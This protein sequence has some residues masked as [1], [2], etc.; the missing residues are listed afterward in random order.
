MPFPHATAPTSTDLR[1][2]DILWPRH[3][4]V[5]VIPGISLES[6]LTQ[7]LARQMGW[8]S[9]AAL[10]VGRE[11]ELSR[12]VLEK[13]MK[14]LGLP[15]D[16]PGNAAIAA[17]ALGLLAV[18]RNEM[19]PEALEPNLG[20]WINDLNG[21]LDAARDVWTEPLLD[22]SYL[23][24][25][26]GGL[27]PSDL[28]AALPAGWPGG[29]GAGATT[30]LTRATVAGAYVGHL[31][32]VDILDGQPWVIES[33]YVAGGVQITPYA[34]W[35]HHRQSMEAHVWQGR[36]VRSGEG[37]EP[38]NA[39]QL[40]TMLDTAHSLRMQRKRYAIFDRT[41]AGATTPLG[42]QD[43]VYCSELVYLSARSVGVDLDSRQGLA[44]KLPFLG[45]KAISQSP[46]VRMVFRP[47][48]QAY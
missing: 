18:L 8:P 6:D 33:S 28:Q 16:I 34:T 9:P 19:V 7:W 35:L 40:T 48:S 29:A 3:P 47:G 30:V 17:G 43:M 13:W 21:V 31:G 23:S 24:L 46:H 36:V 45:P 12:D 41:A 15:I 32:M 39:G 20:D 44:R 37:Q 25:A 10:A 11:D 4:D 26:L 14:I 1:K 22:L 38:L 27:W 42:D 2:G 5:T